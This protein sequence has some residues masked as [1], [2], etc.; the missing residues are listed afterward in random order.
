MWGCR[1]GLVFVAAAGCTNT[2]YGLA[3]YPFQCSEQ[4]PCATGVECIDGLCAAGEGRVCSEDIECRDACHPAAACTEGRCVLGAEELV[5]D[6]GAYRMCS[7]A[8]N[9]S[10]ILRH[11]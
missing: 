5:L 1:L 3:S 7:V 2:D 10:D 11:T 6:G 9:C 8:G 4:E